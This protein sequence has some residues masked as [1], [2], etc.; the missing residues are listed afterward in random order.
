[1][2]VK[3]D[4]RKSLQENAAVYFELAKSFAKKADG[5]KKA[6]VETE[7]KL[8]QSISEKEILQAPKMKRK[9]D[10]YEKYHWFFTSEKKL[11]VAGRDAKQNDQLVLSVMKGQD[12]FF[13]A[14]I[15]GAPATILFDGKNSSEQEKRETAQFAASHSSAWKIGA[16]SVDVYFVQK[17]QLSKAAHGGYVGKGGFAISGKREWIRAVP[18]GLAIVAQENRAVCLPLCHPEARKGVVVLPGKT[19][20]GKAAETIAKLIGVEKEE[21]LLV[22]PAGKFSIK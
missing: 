15:Q 11:V 9:K 8:S 6:I 16:A 4:I 22:L 3:L 19:E 2:K 13:H 14:D 5:V 12:L 17:E 1:M 21:I 7:K 10:W 20:K 18:L